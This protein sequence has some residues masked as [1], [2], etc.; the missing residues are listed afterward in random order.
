MLVA[1]LGVEYKAYVAAFVAT[2][3]NVLVLCSGSC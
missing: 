2:V 3:E 1:V